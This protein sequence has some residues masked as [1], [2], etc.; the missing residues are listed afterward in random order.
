MAT[1]SYE[2][3]SMN[4][5][6]ARAMTVLDDPYLED[7]WTE[8]AYEHV[9]QQVAP[10][11]VSRLGALYAFVDPIEAFH[12]ATRPIFPREGGPQ[13]VVTI[14]VPQGTRWRLVDMDRWK[15]CRLAERT[16]AGLREAWTRASTAATE[17]W[18]VEV[19]DVAFAEVLVEGHAVV[20]QAISL[21]DTLVNI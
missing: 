7:V 9:R 10:T 15:V 17:Y 12:F 21:L 2:L 11:S 14:E 8:L 1:P 19:A 18:R 5:D 20:G 16:E 6:P 4:P 3:L 13:V